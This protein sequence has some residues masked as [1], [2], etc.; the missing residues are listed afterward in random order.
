[1]LERSPETLRVVSTPPGLEV[2][3]IFRAWQTILLLSG[4]LDMASA[5]T[6]V[7]T[8]GCAARGL[9]ALTLDLSRLSFIDSSGVLAVLNA[10]DVCAILEAPLWLVPGP[11][12]VQRV[13]EMM[14]VTTSLSWATSEEHRLLGKLSRAFM[15]PAHLKGV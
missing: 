7:G 11:Q 5:S 3:A 9:E 8:V 2:L 1:M 14:G 13:F 4:E 6:L 10:R 15:C 12:A